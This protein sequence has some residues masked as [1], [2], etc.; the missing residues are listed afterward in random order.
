MHDPLEALASALVF[1]PDRIV[2]DIGLPIIDGFRLARS[3]HDRAETRASLLIALPGYG[4]H[5]APVT[6]RRTSTPR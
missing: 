5:A 2:L 3:L 4:Q 6:P 1:A